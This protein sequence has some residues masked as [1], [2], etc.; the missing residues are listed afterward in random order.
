MKGFTVKV[1]LVILRPLC[2]LVAELPALCTLRSLAVSNR[3]S[4]VST[5]GLNPCRMGTRQEL[6]PLQ[7]VNKQPLWMNLTC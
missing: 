6:W 3:K 2:Y 1:K 7:L 5:Q 4:L